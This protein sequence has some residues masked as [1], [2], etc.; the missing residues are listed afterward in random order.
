VRPLSD[1]SLSPTPPGPGWNLL[2]FVNP[3]SF[4][5][6]SPP[7]FDS[8]KHLNSSNNSLFVHPKCPKYYCLTSS[9]GYVC[10]GR[11]Q[12]SATP[13]Y[14]VFVFLVEFTM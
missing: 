13:C 8:L 11:R 5:S 12:K 3:T 2:A 4:S 9:V 14:V 6:R 10:Y 7:Q 1:S